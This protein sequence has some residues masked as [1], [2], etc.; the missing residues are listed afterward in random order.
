MADVPEYFAGGILVHNCA[1][2]HGKH[3]DQVDGS[4][5]AFT[6]LDNIFRTTVGPNPLA[7]YQGRTA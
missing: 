2:P 6:C 1:F 3:D 5:G 7:G 4:S